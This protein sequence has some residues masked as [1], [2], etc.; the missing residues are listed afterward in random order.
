MAS[1]SDV[2]S[3]DALWDVFDDAR[4]FAWKDHENSTV[5]PR[6]SRKYLRQWASNRGTGCGSE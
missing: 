1:R 3:V 2:V 6:T 4:S 5:C